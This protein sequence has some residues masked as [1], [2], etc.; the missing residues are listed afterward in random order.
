MRKGLQEK[1]LQKSIVIK[2]SMCYISYII[3]GDVVGGDHWSSVLRKHYPKQRRQKNEKKFKNIS[4]VVDIR[5]YIYSDSII[6]NG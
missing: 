1:T 2:I 3:L 4:N 6:N 5:Y